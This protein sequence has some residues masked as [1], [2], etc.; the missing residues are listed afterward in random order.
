[1]NEDFMKI[2]SISRKMAMNSAE[3]IEHWRLALVEDNGGI[4][5]RVNDDM[6]VWL[7]SLVR[8]ENLLN[9][10]EEGLSPDRLGLGLEDSE[11]TSADPLPL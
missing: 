3:R 11:V 2:L 6:E 8:I 7:N 1:M 4:P 9:E 10:V 5:E